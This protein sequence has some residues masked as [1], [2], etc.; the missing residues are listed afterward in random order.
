MRRLINALVK[1]HSYGRLTWQRGQEMVSYFVRY[2]GKTVDPIAFA[3]YYE[4]SHAPILQRFPGIRSLILHQPASWNDP[5]QVRDDG[6]SMLAQ[7]TFAA[8]ADLDR[9][10]TSA[11]RQ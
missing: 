5:F 2:R 3:R 6:T 11:G 7:M 9:A 1:F 8:V 10:I 4:T